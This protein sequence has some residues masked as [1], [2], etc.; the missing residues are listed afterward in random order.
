MGLAIIIIVLAG[1]VG[2][3]VMSILEPMFSMY[4][5]LSL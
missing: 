4:N 2:F 1:V 5:N 3:V